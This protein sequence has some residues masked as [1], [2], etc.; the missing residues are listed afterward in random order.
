MNIRL[1]ILAILA[2]LISVQ[3]TAE[4]YQVPLDFY[5]NPEKLRAAA[6]KAN[7]NGL[8]NMGNELLHLAE[9]AEKKAEMSIFQ[10]LLLGDIDRAVNAARLSGH[11]FADRPVKLKPADPNDHTWKIQYE[12][13]P[14]TVVNAKTMFELHTQ[15]IQA[16]GPSPYAGSI[17]KIMKVS[18]GETSDESKER[19]LRMRLLQEQR[20]AIRLQE[21]Q[22]NNQDLR[23]NLQIMQL[24]G[25]QSTQGSNHGH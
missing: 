20:R 14:E 13:S 25:P 16:I 23:N 4:I 9:R 15:L 22:M 2:F 11:P 12:G 24:L 5:D 1:P 7:N 10:G 18:S 8:V 6:A 21:Q 17:E 3:A 19:E